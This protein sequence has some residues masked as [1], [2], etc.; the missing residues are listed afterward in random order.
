MGSAMKAFVFCPCSE[1]L[2]FGS[3]IDPSKLQLDSYPH[4]I[5]DQHTH[6][7]LSYLNFCE[8]CQSVK[9]RK[10]IEP[11]V[12]IK[13]CPHCL[14]EMKNEYNFCSRNCLNCPLCDGEVVIHQSSSSSGSGGGGGGGGGKNF[15]MKCGRCD[16]RWETGEL[17]KNRALTRVVKNQLNQKESMQ[18][19]SQLE[20]M[21]LQ[22]KQ[23]FQGN[24]QVSKDT[25][26]QMSKL[27]LQDDKFQ[28]IQSFISRK[29]IL[30]FPQEQDINQSNLMAQQTSNNEIIPYIQSLKSIIPQRF[31]QNIPPNPTKL[32]TKISKRCKA[33]RNSLMKPDKDPISV[34]FYKLS[35]AIDYLPTINIHKHPSFK[36]FQTIKPS[37]LIKYLCSF[38]NPLDIPMKLTISTYSIT[39]GNFPHKV[40]LPFFEFELGPRPE[41]Y[42][43]LEGLIKTIPTVELSKETKMGRIE[44][45]NRNI[46][47][48]EYDL[49]DKGINWCTLP[50]Q[51]QVCSNGDEDYEL[52]VPIFITVKTDFF[53]SGYWS[54]LKFGKVIM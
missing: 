23:L 18:R 36:E 30:K 53:S 42:S 6:H 14:L 39:P 43:K 3:I 1:P 28:D 7:L 52:E 9:C 40:H 15:K 2:D 34:K 47:N 16:W 11:E 45:M 32:K 19:F 24:F 49:M 44:L 20:T 27:K 29:S 48:F 51:I 41:N 12:M 46:V 10:C 4:T 22:K 8:H 54:I 38:Q 21:Y 13:Y 31:K 37:I 5:K 25:A 35:N 17:D 26:V 50:I 33:C